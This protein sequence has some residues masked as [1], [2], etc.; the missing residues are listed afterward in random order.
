[1]FFLQKSSLGVGSLSIPSFCTLSA[2]IFSAGI[3]LSLPSLSIAD[4]RPSETGIYA[5]VSMGG[6]GFLGDNKSYTNP[7]PRM[8]L[9]VGT[10]LFSWFSLGGRITITSHEATV[11][12]PPVGEYLQFYQAAGEARLGLSLGPVAF[13]AEGIVGVSTMSTNILE[14]VAILD[15]GQRTS[16]V[17]GG[18]GGIE[19][20]LQNRHYALGVM[21]GWAVYPSFSSLQTAE[22]LSYL[23]YTY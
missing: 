18:G 22:A 1:M 15:P 11:P 10:D 9:H 6:S 13:Y 4:T 17:F 23:R 14:K 8:N 5:Q 21:G 3:V 12:A 20:Q 16:L 2:G 19:Y 7:G